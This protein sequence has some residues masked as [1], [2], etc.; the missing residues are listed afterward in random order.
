MTLNLDLPP[1]LEHELYTEA[2]QLNLPL[3]EYVLRVLATRQA[4]ENLPQTG[5]ELVAYWQ[6]EGVIN[7]RPDITDSQAHA[8]K[9]RNEAETRKRG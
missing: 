1:E 3:N 4:S 8:R 2:S 9:L 5:A 7:S 6:R